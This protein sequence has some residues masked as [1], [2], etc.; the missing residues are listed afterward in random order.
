MQTRA[1]FLKL[2]ALG[3]LLI[4]H[5]QITHACPTTDTPLKKCTLNEESRFQLIKQAIIL[6]ETAGKDCSQTGCPSSP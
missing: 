5:A 4:A 1:L 2:L 3:V 6:T